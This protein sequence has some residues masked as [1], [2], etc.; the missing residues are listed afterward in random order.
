MARSVSIRSPEFGTLGEKEFSEA[1]R[2]RSVLPT[3]FSGPRADLNEVP[4]GLARN[5]NKNKD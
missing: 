5:T 4:H 1:D 2:G 3:L